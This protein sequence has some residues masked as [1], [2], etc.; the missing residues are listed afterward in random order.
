MTPQWVW[1]TGDVVVGM[2]EPFHGVRYEEE[3]EQHQKPF[4][5]FFFFL[6]RRRKRFRSECNLHSHDLVW[7]QTAL[8]V[9]GVGTPTQC[10]THSQHGGIE[11]AAHCFRWQLQ[12][13]KRGRGTESQ[14]RGEGA[15]LTEIAARNPTMVPRREVEEMVSRGWPLNAS[16]SRA[17]TVENSTSH[18]SRFCL[19]VTHC[20]IIT[21]SPL[22]HYFTML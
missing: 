19:Q 10:P 3:N 2:G 15:R 4:F 12:Q 16:C 14:S 18:V 22:L 21:S 9:G 11:E 6:R 1:L 8:L 7:Q 17:K 5:F 13:L 20:I